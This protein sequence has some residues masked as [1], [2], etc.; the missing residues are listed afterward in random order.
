M[1]TRCCSTILNVTNCSDPNGTSLGVFARTG[2][3]KQQD[4]PSCS[5]I[6]T[7][8]DL[9]SSPDLGCGRIESYIM[10]DDIGLVY[11][12]GPGSLVNAGCHSC[13]NVDLHLGLNRGNQYPHCLHN[14][15]AGSQL[16]I[17]YGKDY[18][19]DIFCADCQNALTL[20]QKPDPKSL[21]INHAA[22][23]NEFKQPGFNPLSTADVVS[24]LHAEASFYES[25]TLKTRRE[26]STDRKL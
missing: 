18:R 13:A 15:S 17:E 20:N 22:V 26:K 6:Q 4:L 12:G 25:L 10:R 24:A 23:L 3:A 19:P 11:I 16:L 9:S 5:Y 1:H 21:N 8:M 2:L 14:L 7:Q